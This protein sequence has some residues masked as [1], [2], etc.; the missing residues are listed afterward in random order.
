MELAFTS[1]KTSLSAGIRLLLVEDDASIRLALGDMLEDEGF[2]V[3]TAINGR[4]ALDALRMSTA[5]DII[6]LDLM[7]PVMDGWEFR[8]EQ[9]SDPALAGIPLLAMSA[10]LSAKA[11][12]IAADGYIRKPIDFPE[13]VHKLREVVARAT[14]QRLAAADRM[15]ALGT[16]ASGIA[17]EINN[18]LTYVLANLQTLA[19]RLPASSD[20]STRELS[21]VV[22][23]ALD[24]AERIRK[25]VKQVQMVSPGQHRDTIA[26]FSLREAVETAIVLT[27]NQIRHRAQLVTDLDPDISVRGDRERI[28]QLIVNLLLNAAQA[29]PEGHASENRIRVSVREM[30]G[31]QAAVVE[32]E[33]TG[34][35]IPVELHERIFQP[36]FTTKTI[37]QGTGLG[38]SICRGIVTALGG[39]IS[40][41][42]DGDS[43]T[44]FRVVLPT[45]TGPA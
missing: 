43:G 44:T 3:T 38:L 10:D 17:H 25:L 36:F 15:A 23:D 11:R 22:A 30:P 45:T 34:A 32:V 8:V 16:L 20:S 24:G 35:G 5:P 26:I 42:S 2:A 37:G 4:E 21:D 33:D 39:Q 41:Q 29:I 1:N 18:P 7:M 14:R 28:E 27:E 12:A 13:M 31:Q 19:E 40:F 6:V 9:R